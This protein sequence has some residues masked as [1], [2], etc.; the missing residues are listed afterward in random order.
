VD[1]GSIY[2]V[3]WSGVFEAAFK[4]FIH[5]ALSG[6][7]VW[8]HQVTGD[9]C[10]SS[11]PYTILMVLGKSQR[12]NAQLAGES[13][14]AAKTICSDLTTCMVSQVEP[15][16]VEPAVVK[17]VYH[18]V[19]HCIFHMSISEENTLTQNDGALLRIKTTS[20]STVAGSAY[21]V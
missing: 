21:D 8:T 16:D 19:K 13:T 6:G 2:L 17:H 7:L 20:G 4:D 11:S 15:V 18:F 10:D 12:A 3:K 14:I 9:R 1:D 5:Y